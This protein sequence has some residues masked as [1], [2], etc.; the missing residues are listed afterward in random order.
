MFKKA[1]VNP[2]KEANNSNGA[3]ITEE[4]KVAATVMPRSVY[5]SLLVHRHA[6]RDFTSFLANFSML[7]IAGSTIELLGDKKT[8]LEKNEV[9]FRQQLK[10]DIFKAYPALEELNASAVNAINTFSAFTK[11][12]IKKLQELGQSYNTPGQD[13]TLYWTSVIV[14]VYREYM[15][16]RLSHINAVYDLLAKTDHY[17]AGLQIDF[18]A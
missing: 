2:V 16:E 12:Y 7:G 5:Q 17:I 8:A 10:P 4:K 18:S 15:M 3:M 11:G 14:P 13:K 6:M 1:K 9:Q